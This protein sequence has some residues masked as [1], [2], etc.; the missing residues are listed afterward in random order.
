M[1]KTLLAIAFSLIFTGQTALAAF[2][3]TPTNHPYYEG[4]SYLEL[5]GAVDPGAN[6]RPDDP[7]T[8]AELFKILFK[9]L[10]EDADDVPTNLGFEDVPEDA[11]F[12]PY[13]K[14]AKYYGLSSEDVFDGSQ[15][16][17]RGTV[18]GLVMKAYGLGTPVIP[19]TDRSSLF[20]DVGPKHPLYSLIYQASKVGLVE[21][22]LQSNY[23]PYSKLTRGELADLLFRADA[24]KNETTMVSSNE[25]FYKGDIFESIWN[26]VLNDFYLPSGYEIDQ[27][28]LFEAAISGMLESLNDPYSKY[29]SQESAGEFSDSLS[30]EFEGIGAMLTQDTETFEVFI[31]SVLADSPAEKVGLLA[32]DKITEV[33]EISTEGMLL[34]EV[35]GRIK[36]PADTEVKLTIERN[37]AELFFVVTRAQ[38]TLDLV[39]GKIYNDDA[40]FIDIDSFASNLSA[41]IDQTFEDL[42]EEEAN[43]SAIIF[44]LRGN[45]GGYLNMSN[46][47]AGKFLAKDAPLVTLDYG[48][49]KQTLVNAEDG[50]YQGVPLFILVDSYSASASEIMTLTLQEVANA[51]VIGTQSFGKGSAQELVTYW[52]GS[53]L[54]LTIAHWLSA[55]GTSIQGIGVTPDVK[56]T[57]GD[58][59]ADEWLRALDRE[60]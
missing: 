9:T 26:T 53:M 51:T 1:K 44:D 55:E 5:I 18:L 6:F 19:Y 42:E 30:G 59:E 4:I 7:V 17:S 57:E 35:I 52:D 49:F 54:K 15:T 22:S 12:A 13:A 50:P 58:G 45:P 21:S 43:P 33:D 2:E 60:L 27:Q 20:N 29:F 24:W 37:N 40:W 23:L 11:W 8:R 36:G 3:D 32:G 14:L 34:E 28:V 48:S 56:V 41:D 31:T 16:L 10:H 38:L 46:Y 47:I 25:D 39:R